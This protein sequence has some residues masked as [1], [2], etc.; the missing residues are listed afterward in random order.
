VGEASFLQFALGDVGVN[1]HE[2]G[3]AALLVAHRRDAQV[4]PEEGAVLTVVAYDHPAF[5]L[6]ADRCTYLF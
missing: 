6:L 1:P 2:G 3:E 4:L 5:P